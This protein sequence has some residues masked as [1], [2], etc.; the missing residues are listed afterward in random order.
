MGGRG[1]CAQRRSSSAILMKDKTFRR[2]AENHGIGTIHFV[3]KNISFPFPETMVP[4]NTNIT[5]EGR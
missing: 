4:L 5:D 2:C 1:N 3:V